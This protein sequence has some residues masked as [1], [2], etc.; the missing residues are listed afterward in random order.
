MIHRSQ[1]IDDLCMPAAVK[2]NDNEVVD[3]L[4]A[5]R[6]LFCEHDEAPVEPRRGTSI[7]LAAVV[8]ISKPDSTY[9][10]GCRKLGR[11]GGYGCG[12]IEDVGP[13]WQRRAIRG[14]QRQAGRRRGGERRSLR[15][16]THSGK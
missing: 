8:T 11:G 3:C 6:C 10:D 12:A 9:G 2:D 13:R 7:R 15:R 1:S 14:G 16:A 4:S 5:N